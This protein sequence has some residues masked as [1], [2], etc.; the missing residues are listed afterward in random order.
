MNNAV[1]GSPAVFGY[2][3]RKELM[4]LLLVDVTPQFSVFD[5]YFVKF[6]I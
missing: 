6:H 1:L 4:N 3:L 2:L 5:S